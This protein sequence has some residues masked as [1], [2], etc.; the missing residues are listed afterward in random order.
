MFPLRIKVIISFLIVVII[1]GS[2]ATVVGVH[3][4]GEGIIKQTQ[5]KIRT[6]L[7]SA[8]EIYQ[9]EENDIKT[10]VRLT[11]ERFYIKDSLIKNDLTRLNSEIATVRERESLD[12]L[13]IL[14]NQGRVIIRP[15]NTSL[16]GD[17]QTWSAIVKNALV[18]KDTFAGTEIVSKE[19][20][21]KCS[22]E[23]AAQAY[24]KFISTPH[25]KPTNKT[26][27]ISGM[28]IK[29]AAPVLDYNGNILGILYGG[30]LI[31]RNYKIVDKIKETVFQGQVYKGKDIGT[32]TIFQGD[33]RISTNVKNKEGERAIGTRL[34]E[35]VYEQVL[36]KGQP[37]I[38]R[39]FVVNNWYITAYEP[40]K[41]ISNEIIGILYVGILEDK[42]V[43]MKRETIWLL[44]SITIIGVIVALIVSYFLA[45]SITEPI[46]HLALASQ[47][48][49]KGDFNQE[50]DV[51]SKDEI[52]ELGNAFNF[53]ISSIKE[54][55]EKLRQHTQQVV[56]RSERLAMIGQ[57]A[58]GVAHEIN[59]PLAGLRTYVKL[60]NKE[61]SD[62][63][64][65]EGS[66]PKYLSLMER[67][68]IR[69]S[70]VV[71]NLLNFA[72]QTDTRLQLV[73]INHIL[74]EALSFIEH[75]IIMLDI[76]VEKNFGTLPQTVADF[77]QLQQVFMNIILNAC[78][79]MTT[80]GQLLLSANYLELVN[81]IEIKIQDTGS[82]IPPEILPRIFEPFFTTKKKG[83][84]LG[85]SVAYGIISQHKGTIE[86]NST[87][88]VGTTFI[89]KLPVQQSMTKNGAS[90]VRD[91]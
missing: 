87:V 28:V 77:S 80:K 35:D 43:D 15:R 20:L 66:F 38:E 64:I 34:A 82:G 54:R 60:I 36:V 31:N 24:F 56:V 27:E 29:A 61:I 67:E 89:I 65:P 69:C 40:I 14:D 16:V 88:G 81:Q 32:A 46:H 50:V 74:N 25:A 58:A 71:R 83:T 75:Q 53:M 19:E 18:Y 68:T 78:E 13:T 51:K 26:E 10:V 33:L 37:W 42:F 3:L 7:N 9:R 2:V 30:N 23:L 84:G 86:V 63:G 11:A 47:E 91:V 79:S 57:L 49:A 4:I 17:D 90:P 72:R 8:R 48:L 73:D 85:L 22:P 59:N 41:N 76:K 45:K 39:A 70:E 12:F 1:T 44:I 5:D 62:L 6:D 21:L 55:D 52:G